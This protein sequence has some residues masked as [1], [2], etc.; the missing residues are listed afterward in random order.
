MLT[1]EKLRT[2]PVNRVIGDKKKFLGVPL[3]EHA[4][5]VGFAFGSYCL[6]KLFRLDAPVP[7]PFVGW[8]W[9]SSVCLYVVTP[10]LVVALA[11]YKK[12]NP[13][14]D[15]VSAFFFRI[16]PRSLRAGARDLT[17]RPVIVAPPRPKRA[18]TPRATGRETTPR[19][20]PHGHPVEKA[21]GEGARDASES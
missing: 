19:R 10:A 5:V 12:K 14:Y 16:E 6:L 18:A 13:N 4:L 9:L 1:E 11:A 21:E 8:V 20:G 15:L 17:Y 3:E 7:P 2:R